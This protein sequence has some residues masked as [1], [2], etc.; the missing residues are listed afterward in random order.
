MEKGKKSKMSQPRKLRSGKIV[1]E[2]GLV[3]FQETKSS[4]KNERIEK[5]R[6]PISDLPNEK[7]GTTTNNDI[8]QLNNEINSMKNQMIIMASKYKQN[9]G[10][11]NENQRDI[12]FQQAFLINTIEGY[13]LTEMQS[14]I[15]NL[16]NEIWEIKT[17]FNN[18][19]NNLHARIEKQSNQ[20]RELKEKVITKGKNESIN[21]N[22]KNNEYMIKEKEINENRIVQNHGQ[23]DQHSNKIKKN[24]TKANKTKTQTNEQVSHYNDID[25]NN[26]KDTMQNM[27]ESIQ[28]QISNQSN[29]TEKIEEK[30]MKMNQQ[31]H[32]L[33]AKYI[34][35]NAKINH[36]TMDL[37]KREEKLSKEIRGMVDKETTEFMVSEDKDERNNQLNMNK[38]TNKYRDVTTNHVV[39]RNYDK[40]GYMS[41]LSIRMQNIE[42][43]DLRKFKEDVM[44]YMERKMKMKCVKNVVIRRYGMMSNT[45]NWAN[46]IVEFDCPI[47]Q[48]YLIAINFPKNWECMPMSAAINQEQ[49]KRKSQKKH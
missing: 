19:R 37:K 8:T 13:K 23:L 35:F 49:Y 6:K 16:N 4:I 45:I 2:R 22:S 11:I 21:S 24:L 9:I 20:I 33:S 1:E 38:N 36:F 40:Y 32:V 28:K 12:K 18:E 14:N 30:L 43:N 5:E 29:T 31:I 39:I 41:S 46:I 44:I 48:D 7:S 17:K 47:N 10:Q 25:F 15:E 3:V 26:M 42:V 34:N 27:G